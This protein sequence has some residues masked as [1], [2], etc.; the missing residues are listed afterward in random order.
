MTIF[1][2]LAIVSPMLSVIFAAMAFRRNQKADD[3][4]FAQKQAVM[5]EKI[6]NIVE[7][8]DELAKKFDNIVT[9]VNRLYTNLGK[10]E[11]RITAHEGWI[12]KLE[13]KQDGTKNH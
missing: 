4:S 8:L 12:K 9:D 2:V 7:R 3:V 11:E 1:E 6:E 10:I 5:L 13:E